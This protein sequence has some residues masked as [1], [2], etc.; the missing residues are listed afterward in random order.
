MGLAKVADFVS[1][2]G[3]EGVAGLMIGTLVGL[4][5]AL[6]AVDVVAK[7]FITS[8]LTTTPAAASAAGAE[9]TLA[10]SI[11]AAAASLTNATVAAAANTP[12][13]NAA[14]AGAGRASVGFGMLGRSLL[15][16]GGVALGA[17][18]VFFAIKELTENAEAGRTLQSIAVGLAAI[19]GIV[20]ALAFAFGVTGGIAAGG[21]L[22][23][24]GVIAAAIA[25]IGVAA[26]TYIPVF[27][28]FGRAF[29]PLNDLI[30]EES[31]GRLGTFIGK[32]RELK[33]ALTGIPEQSDF[34]VMVGNLEDMNTSMSTISPSQYEG[35]VNL[36]NAANTAEGDE[37][38]TRAPAALTT[39]ALTAL[40][41]AID[42]TTNAPPAALARV[43][44]TPVGAT[45]PIEIRLD[46]QVLGRWLESFMEKR[47]RL[48][49]AGGGAP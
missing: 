14:G 15:I 47:Y 7:K 49:V 41:G 16:I 21:F 29:D 39:A 10:A 32:I 45:R 40:L 36:I 18:G 42:R 6:V 35:A 2:M 30:Q 23:A 38:A 27:N 43:P 48:T 3:P 9:T 1:K 4:K 46:G 22:T 31:I 44:A 26:M 33:A 5:V 28:A 34:S 8:L 19:T 13:I 12:V 37:G 24:A 11:N 25:M 20:S 17:I